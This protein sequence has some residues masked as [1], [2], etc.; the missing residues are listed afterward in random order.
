MYVRRKSW[1]L[2]GDLPGLGHWLPAF[3]GEEGGGGAPPKAPAAPPAGGNGGGG[4]PKLAELLEQHPHLQDELKKLASREKDQGLRSGANE[5]ARG[6]GFDTPD[7]LLEVVRKYQ[8]AEQAKLSDADRAQQD[9][10][11]TRLEAA[12]LLEQAKRT[13][14]EAN[15]VAAL[16]AADAQDPEFLAAGLEKLGVT[17]DSTPDEIKAAVEEMRKRMPGA[18]GAPAPGTP[19]SNPGTPP[20]AS[21]GASGT[22]VGELGAEARRQLERRVNRGGKVPIPGMR[23]A[24]T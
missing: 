6:Q 11:R 13:A 17:V 14:F 21:P 8:E 5:W 12:S 19:G 3:E 22:G 23:S 4:K 18:F 1:L 15:A 2:G 20:A 9:A 10:Q 7:A 24:A 16:R